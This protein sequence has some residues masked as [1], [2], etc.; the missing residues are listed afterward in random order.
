VTDI[1]EADELLSRAIAALKTY[2]QRDETGFYALLGEE[3]VPVLMIII[4]LLD[5][6]LE[7]HAGPDWIDEQINIMLDRRREGHAAS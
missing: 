5:G 4:G 7:N 2:R 6:W 1:P 3:Q